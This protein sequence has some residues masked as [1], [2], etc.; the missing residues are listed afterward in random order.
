MRLVIIA[1]VVIASLIIG[2]F[3]YRSRYSADRLLV[4]P[5]PGKRSEKAK[6]H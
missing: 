2:I 3:V 4:D 5:R 1:L 6:H